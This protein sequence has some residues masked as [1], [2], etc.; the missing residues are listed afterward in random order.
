M[1]WWG[2][3]TFNCKNKY[4]SNKSKSEEN[5][6]KIKF[7]K[8]STTT[9]F[10]SW[11]PTRKKIWPRNSSLK[12]SSSPWCPIPPTLM[13]SKRKIKY[14]PSCWKS[15]KRAFLNHK[16]RTPKAKFNSLWICWKGKTGT[17]TWCS[18]SCPNGACQAARSW[19]VSTRI[20]KRC[21]KN[22]WNEILIF[23]RLWNLKFFRFHV[24]TWSFEW[25][26]NELFNHSHL[27][28]NKNI[29]EMLFIKIIKSK[30]LCIEHKNERI[31]VH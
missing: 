10:T 21:R 22:F 2:R 13:K 1:I 14:W 26:A 20:C 12:A 16:V 5:Y 29:F 3:I 7:G 4:K 27:N 15:I 11:L 18:K 23:F 28:S 19:K 8:M 6:L 17:I 25:W 31:A 9:L 30:N 24:R